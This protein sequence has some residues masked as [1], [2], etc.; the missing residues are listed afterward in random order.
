MY[1]LPEGQIRNQPPLVISIHDAILKEFS[2]AIIG[3]RWYPFAPAT[4]ELLQG[5][6]ND[7]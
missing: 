1:S 6:T 3:G 4:I 2:G 5:N 7:E